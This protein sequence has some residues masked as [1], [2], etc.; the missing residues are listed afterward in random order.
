MDAGKLLGALMQGGLNNAGGRR[1]ENAFGGGGMGQMGGMLGGLLDGSAGGSGGGG[2]LGDI[3]GGLMGGGQRQGG[4]GLGDLLGGLMGGGDNRGGGGAIS[5]LGMLAMKVLANR[6]GQANQLS[7]S[8]QLT[9]GLRAPETAE[10]EQTV[11]DVALLTLKAMINAAKADGRIDEGELDRI[12]GKLQEDGVDAE[13]QAFIRAELSAPM[14][15]DGLV[16]AVPNVQV[17]LQIYTASLLAIQVDTAAEQA[18]L[19]ELADKLGLEDETVRQ[20]HTML[21]VG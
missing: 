19:R 15:T 18:Y 1:L 12:V 5:V 8:M 6:G 14:D 11:Q 13:E 20:V 2:G 10:E 3:L 17:G 16:A 4:G 9:A 21:G 7:S